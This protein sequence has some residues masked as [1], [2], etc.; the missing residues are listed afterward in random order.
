MKSITFTCEVVTPMFLAGADGQKSELRSSS[1]KGAMRFW[2]RTMHGDLKINALREKEFAI[3]GGGG[4]HA[5]KSKISI[6]VSHLYAKS[7]VSLP[8]K[9]ISMPSPVSGNVGRSIDGDLF[10]YL[11]YGAED[12]MYYP[13][14]YEFEVK[15]AYHDVHLSFD[16]AILKPFYLLSFFGGLGA[17]S[18]N[19]FGSFR[20]K[21]CSDKQ[22][23]IMDNPEIFIRELYSSI[24]FGPT[25]LYT[26]FSNASKLFKT[27][28][29]KDTWCECLEILGKAYAI[30][31]RKMEYAHDYSKRAYIAAPIMQSNKIEWHKERHAKPYFISVTKN[32]KQYDGWILFLPYQHH[33]YTN[34]ESATTELNEGLSSHLSNIKI[35]S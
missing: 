20:I 15:F 27:N 22:V 24:L 11:A 17:K 18:R 19:G 29:S 1:I 26:A 34:Y 9:S 7:D 2:W 16:D 32:D 33:N 30:E 13:P 35:M 25:C 21:K 28:D 23:E 3:Y 6:S 5:V 4:E 12:R 14:K 8:P 31:K 10:K